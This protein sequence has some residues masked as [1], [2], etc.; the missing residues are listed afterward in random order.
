MRPLDSFDAVTQREPYF[1]HFEFNVVSLGECNKREGQ[2]VVVSRVFTGIHRPTGF[3][4]S[5]M[6]PFSDF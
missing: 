3:M 5:E 4:Y 2:R 6:K 1:A